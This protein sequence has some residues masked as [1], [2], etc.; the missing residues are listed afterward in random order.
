MRIFYLFRIEFNTTNPAIAEINDAANMPILAICTVASSVKASPD[1]K[2][3]IVKPIPA[4][5]PTP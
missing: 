5:S 1:I 2:I 3:D 4:S